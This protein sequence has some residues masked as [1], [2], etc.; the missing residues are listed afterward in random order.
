MYN[1]LSQTLLKMTSPGIPDF[2]QGSE[3]WDLSL[4]DPDNRRPVDFSKRIA[5]LQEI[6]QRESEIGPRE[7]AREL[8][9]TRERGSI[10]LYLIYKCLNYRKENRILFEKGEYIVLEADDEKGD[11][12]CSFARRLGNKKIIVVVPRFFTKIIDASELLPFGEKIWSDSSLV[13]SLSKD[14]AR[15]RNIF[16]DEIVSAKNY[17]DATVLKLSDI[18]SSFP[19]ALLERVR[20]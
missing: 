16:T 5:L 13:V 19:V 6:K 12:I 11:V 1:S 18:F 8:T 2:Y 15:Y 7:L 4:V 14:G 3:I 10:K 9:A 17:N 20:V